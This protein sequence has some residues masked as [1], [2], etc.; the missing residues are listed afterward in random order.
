MCR[1]DDEDNDGEEES[2]DVWEKKEITFLLCVLKEAVGVE[3]VRH[4]LLLLLAILLLMQAHR[5]VAALHYA[6]NSA[7]RGISGSPRRV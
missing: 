3:L 7:A 2:C 5:L 4:M 1:G 6:S